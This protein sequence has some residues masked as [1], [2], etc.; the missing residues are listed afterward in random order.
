[1]FIPIVVFPTPGARRQNNEVGLLKAVRHL[2][3]LGKAGVY[4]AHGIF[5]RRNDLEFIQYLIVRV[6]LA[7]IDKSGR[8][9]LF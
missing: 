6:V 3:Q 7:H 8:V 1:M 9:R 5:I 4:A 2:I